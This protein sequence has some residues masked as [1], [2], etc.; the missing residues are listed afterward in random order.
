MKHWEIWKFPYPADDRSHWFVIL[1]ST[2][3]CEN[4]NVS[5]VNGLLCTTLRPGGRQL[6]AHEVRLDAADGFEWDTVVKCSH[7]HE[8]PKARAVQG[9]GE[10][11]AARRREIVR[12]VNEILLGV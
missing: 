2:S 3:W 1:S 9:L 7:V 6:K 4:P 5:L 8:L 11:S 12:R 10:I